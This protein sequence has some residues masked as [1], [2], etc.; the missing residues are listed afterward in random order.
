MRFMTARAGSGQTNREGLAIGPVTL[1]DFPRQAFDDIADVW[2]MGRLNKPIGLIRLEVYECET[3][4][5][6]ID[7]EF[8]LS[9]FSVQ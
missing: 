4:H 5:S 6:G 3:Q 1:D 7:F 8:Q 2:H 9:W